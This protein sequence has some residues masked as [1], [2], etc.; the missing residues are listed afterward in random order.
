MKPRRALVIDGNSMIYA[1]HYGLPFLSTP[2]GQVIQGVYGSVRRI[3]QAIKLFNPERMVV[4]WD[5]SQSFKSWR[6]DVFPPYKANRKSPNH[7]QMTR[8]VVDE[9]IEIAMEFLH[10]GM[11]VPCVR[12]PKVEGDDA[13]SVIVEQLVTDGY[14]P[15]IVSPDHDFVQLVDKRVSVFDPMKIDWVKIDTFEE[16]SVNMKPKC[17]M[18]LPTEFLDWMIV[19]GDTGDGVPMVKGLSGKE[20]WK[21]WAPH[22]ELP[23]SMMLETE[24][25]F[26]LNCPR[27]LQEKFLPRWDELNR[28][29]KL[30]DLRYARP[31]VR[32]DVYDFWPHERHDFDREKLLRLSRKYSFNSI[33]AE[34]DDWDKALN[35]YHGRSKR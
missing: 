22:I 1:C 8:I 27:E 6:H 33:V 18:K 3:R 34:I 14:S 4:C 17:T 20:R 23:L 10:E 21:K 28:N 13:V 30:L 35:D 29:W 19:N 26:R 5:G 32:R 16:Q 2:A 24:D 25:S 12:G 9:Q 7:N 15:V 11:L 31:L